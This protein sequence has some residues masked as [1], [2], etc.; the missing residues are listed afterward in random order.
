MVSSSPD[1]LLTPGGG[2]QYSSL[3]ALAPN[4]PVP[5]GTSS[6]GLCVLEQR[7]GDLKAWIN[8]ERFPGY[9]KVDSYSLYAM[10]ESGECPWDTPSCDPAWA[11]GRF[12]L[13]LTRRETGGPGAAGGVGPQ[14][15]EPEVRR[16]SWPRVLRVCQLFPVLPAQ[17]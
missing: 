10:G 13:P 12:M 6:S 15:A 11:S 2:L 4:S 14:W 3:A 16:P 17:V 8:R 7:D 9:S 1:R 5:G